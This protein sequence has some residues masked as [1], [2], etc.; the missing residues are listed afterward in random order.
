MTFDPKASVIILL[1]CAISIPSCNTSRESQVSERKLMQQEPQNPSVDPPPN[2]QAWMDRLT[3]DHEYDPETGFIVAREVIDLPPV[4][5][6]GPPADEAVRIGNDESRLVVIFATAD[7]CAPCQQYKESALNHPKVIEALS[8]PALITTHVEVDQQPELADEVLGSRAIP[9][10]Y[11]FRDGM[12]I[13][14][15]RGQRSAGEL[16]AWLDDQT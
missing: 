10:T 13:S 4:I 9:M 16:L 14:T 1:L 5:V 6:S 11:L 7:R 2:I 3:V 8:S 15:L 12:V